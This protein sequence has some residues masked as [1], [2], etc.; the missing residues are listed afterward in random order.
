MASSVYLRPTG[1]LYGQDAAAA[2]ASGAAGRLAGGAIAYAACEIVEGRLPRVR[3]HVLSYPALAATN[4]GAIKDLRE[5]IEARRTMPFGWESARPMI[6]GIVNVTPDSFS[7]DGIFSDAREAVSHGRTL[8]AAG[9]NILDVGGESTRPGAE[10]VP[11]DEESRRVMPVIEGLVANGAAV[12]VDTRK[13][14]VMQMAADAGAGMINDIT[15]LTYDGDSLPVAAKSRLPVVLMHAAGDPRTMQND[16][17]YDDVVADIYDYL[18]ARIADCEAA[19]IAREKLIADP[20]IGFGKTVQHNLDLLRRFS[21]FH[22]LGVPLLI[23]VSRK[24]FIGAVSGE[25]DARL[26]IPGSIAA[27]LTTVAQ[28]VHAIRVHDVAQTAQAISV[29]DALHGKSELIR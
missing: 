6:M 1:L 19:G 18:A 7:D 11:L 26:R 2:V 12:S 29:W 4:E 5:R 20:G 23:G 15:A 22:G 3:R 27:A 10:P 21:V 14:Q 25:S 9:A 16:P 8:L 28:G 17:C 13:A 24:G